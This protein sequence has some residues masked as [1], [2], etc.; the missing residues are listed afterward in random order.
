MQVIRAMVLMVDQPWWWPHGGGLM[1]VA[2]W[3]WPHGGGRPPWLTY[4]TCMSVG[5]GVHASAVLSCCVAGT[6][7]KSVVSAT[8]DSYRHVYSVVSRYYRSAV[9]EIVMCGGISKHNNLCGPHNA[10]S[11]LLQQTSHIVECKT[12]STL[13]C[14]TRG[15]S[16]GTCTA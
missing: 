7:N 9:P 8:N 3:W 5:C 1:V 4:V 11:R 15:A 10:T 13:H 6:C 12:V 16:I 14:Q 2:S